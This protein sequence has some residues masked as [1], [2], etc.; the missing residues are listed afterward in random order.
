MKGEHGIGLDL[1]K[2]SDGA[3]VVTKLKD[4]PP[5]VVNPASQCAI[6]IMAGD[7]IVA[8]NGQPANTFSEAVKLIRSAQGAVVLT[9]M[10]K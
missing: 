3:A 8:V 1:T 9:F 6:P 10:R 4:L 7:V 5:G 2:N